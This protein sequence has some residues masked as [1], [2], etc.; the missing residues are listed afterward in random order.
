MK[1]NGWGLEGRM[2]RN[3]M[4]FKMKLF[5]I[6]S[7]M[8]AMTGC[9]PHLKVTMPDQL[10]N[11]FSTSGKIDQIL[12]DDEIDLRQYKTLLVLVTN[13]PDIKYTNFIVSSFKNLKY[14]EAVL[15]PV[16]VKLQLDSKGT[17]VTNGKEFAAQ[18]QKNYGNCLILFLNLDKPPGFFYKGH[19]LVYNPQADKVHLHVYREAFAWD[20]LDKPILYP[21]FNGFVDWAQHRTIIT[22]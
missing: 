21:L 17:Q 6:C 16:D 3:K 5:G 18:L 15:S 20:G 10:T 4:S 11:K 12:V 19:L 13:P 7:F 1:R 2:G 14:F 8:I 9:T 22:N